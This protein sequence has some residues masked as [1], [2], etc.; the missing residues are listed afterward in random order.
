MLSLAKEMKSVVD[1]TSKYPDWS[2]RD[3]IKAKLKVELILLLHKH[4]FPPVAN[5]DVYMGDWR[6]QRTLR[7]IT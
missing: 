5:D 4:K 7:K 1:N 6:K 2:K 3:D